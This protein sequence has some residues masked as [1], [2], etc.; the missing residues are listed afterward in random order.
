M[1]KSQRKV[2]DCVKEKLKTPFPFS[3]HE[4]KP[5]LMK[6]FRHLFKIY[7]ETIGNAKQ[8]KKKRKLLDDNQA[9]ALAFYDSL[10]YLENHELILKE[11]PLCM[12]KMSLG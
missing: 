10:W 5:A 1:K 8:K 11:G 9:K 7:K 3:L 2:I 6:I 12:T 4:R